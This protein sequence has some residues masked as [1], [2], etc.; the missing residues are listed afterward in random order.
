MEFG[1]F[2]RASKRQRA[3]VGSVDHRGQNIGSSLQRGQCVLR[4]LRI[5]EQQR[6]GAVRA[7]NLSLRGEIV[8]DGLPESDHSYAMNAAHANRRA[9]PLTSMFIHV[10]FLAMEASL[11]LRIV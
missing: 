11:A 8:H 5:V 4:G 1:R 2:D 10:S 7:D 6:R 3:A 9:A